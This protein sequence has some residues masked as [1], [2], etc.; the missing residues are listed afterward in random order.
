MQLLLCDLVHKAQL[1]DV[2]HKRNNVM[3][4]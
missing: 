4:T 2:A 1:T 3:K